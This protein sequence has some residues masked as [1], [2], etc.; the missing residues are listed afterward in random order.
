M[1]RTRAARAARSA[2]VAARPDRQVRG[3]VEGEH[4]HDRDTGQ[5][6]IAGEQVGEV[7]GEVALRVERDP[8]EQARE[9]DAPDQRRPDTADGVRP[10]PDP[11]P[12]RALALLAPLEREHA[13]DQQDQEQQQ[14]DVEAREHGRVPGRKR[15][16]GRPACDHEPHLVAVP[17][18]PDRLEHRR[19]LPLV[20]WQERQQHAHAE[21]EALEQEVAAPEDSDQDE[22]EDLEIHRQ[23]LRRRLRGRRRCRRWGLRR[24]A[25]G[26][27]HRTCAS[28]RCRR[29][30]AA[31]R[32]LRT[33]TG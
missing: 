8:V 12:R 33:P 17:D 30:G 11:A 5:H 3:S 14:G 15:G 23:L 21:V 4:E 29:R 19:P 10:R 6:R 7:T 27:A 32:A 13:D 20:P 1:D 2:E 26:R 31:R 18:R 28:A 22:P 16:K 25:P 24:S 9:R